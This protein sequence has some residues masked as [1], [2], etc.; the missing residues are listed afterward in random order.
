MTDIASSLEQSSVI[1]TTPNNLC[2]SYFETVTQ[3][4]KSFGKTFSDYPKAK[5]GNASPFFSLITASDFFR[6][7][8]LTDIQ[9]RENLEKAIISSAMLS[10]TDQMTFDGMMR[11]TDIPLSEI[12]KISVRSFKECKSQD[13]IIPNN[14]HTYG[15]YCVIVYKDYRYFNIMYSQSTN[16]YSVRDCNE[17][18]QYDFKDKTKLIKYIV[19]VYNLDKELITD[20][21]EYC[22]I[23]YIVI[24]QKFN[25]TIDEQ[26]ENIIDNN[27]CQIPAINHEIG[28]GYGYGDDNIL[29]YYGD[30]YPRVRVMDQIAIPPKYQNEFGLDEFDG[31][32][33]DN[34]YDLVNIHTDNMEKYG[35]NNN[36]SIIQTETLNMN[37]NHEEK[38]HI[39]EKIKKQKI[40]KT[41]KLQ[42][43]QYDTNTDTNN[44][45]ANNTANNTILNRDSIQ[46][47]LQNMASETE[48][49]FD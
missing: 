21:Y 10:M 42:T 46:C 14:I 38:R 3:Y 35:L 33:A 24:T 20:S 15:D 32:N 22:N 23:E 12:N 1:K 29:E 41:P 30:P 19:D 28:I 36:Y 31:Y 11:N 47:M 6:N 7:N 43:D 5:I 26:I 34:E 45:T 49:Y 48:N 25:H 2:D 4:D 16:M 39:P 8:K 13:S 44:N 9:H 37:N 18:I 27:H 17:T 40:I